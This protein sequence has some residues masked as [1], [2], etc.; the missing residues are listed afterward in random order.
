VRYHCNYCAKDIS[1]VIRIKCAVCQDFDLCV[2][3][4]SVGVELGPHKN[5]HD[6][7]VTDALNFPL[8]DEDWGADEELLLLEGIEMY[9]LGNWGD[10]ADH[11][12]T[13]TAP[14]CKEH[15][16]G[17][18]INVPTY[19]LPDMTRVLTTSE[20]LQ[21]RN[22]E[23]L[24]IGD[25]EWTYDTSEGI[26]KKEKDNTST[27][28]QPEEQPITGHTSHGYS[29]PDLAGWMPLRGDFETE[30][31]N[32]AE[33]VIQDIVFNDDDTPAD[34][35]TKLRL[36]DNYNKKLDDRI[37]R[38]RFIVDHGLLDYKKDKKRSKEEKDIYER[39]RP[40]LRV[41]TKE[42]HEE[43][44]NGLLAERQL[45]KKIED[46][47]KYRKIGVHTLS[48]VQEYEEEKKRREEHSGGRKRDSSSSYFYQDR[49]IGRS[50]RS[51]NR[52]W[53]PDRPIEKLKPK[54]RKHGGPLDICGSPGYDLLSEKERELCSNVRL[55]PSQYIII[56][57]TLLRESLR[58]GHLKKA[59]ARQLIK[60]D[61]NK[62]SRIFD[63]FESNGWINKA[64][65]SAN[66]LPPIV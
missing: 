17:T 21:L 11:V 54:I 58:Q 57:E 38:K 39:L 15:Y 25:S 35:E 13:K 3:C 49:A 48:E 28:Q 7:H 47:K 6:Y 41:M 53:P 40:F 20:S 43:F 8:F 29:Y 33:S 10:V 1:I 45:R 34:I 4:F 46:L 55:F 26:D 36:I 59:V 63:F 5:N 44:I 62:T 51:S 61:V 66:S 22:R 52:N 18:Y 56:K 30:H 42:E 65:T 19:P 2:Q 37:K 16:W 32:D 50:N 12:G 64:A 31:E 24:E 60:I 14:S 23:Q 27:P 9:G